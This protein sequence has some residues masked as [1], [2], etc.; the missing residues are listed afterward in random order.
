MPSILIAALWA[1]FFF[2]GCQNGTYSDI[3]VKE[4]RCEYTVEPAAVNAVNPRLYWVLESAKRGQLQAAYQVL[5]AG[6]RAGLDADKGDLWDTG[7]VNSSQSTHVVYQG[8]KLSSRM[9]C[10]W[11]VRVWDK[12]DKVSAWSKP[13]AWQMGLLDDTDWK[14]NW[15]TIGHRENQDAAPMFRREFKITGPVKEAHVYV[16]GL[17][18]Y[19]L[20]INGQKVGDHVLDPGQT[21]YQQRVFYVA[22]DVTDRLAA[23]GNAI[24][25]IVGDGW[26]NQNKVWL[27]GQYKIE[28]PGPVY[29]K[30]RLLLQLEITYADG[31]SE[32]IITDQR[33]KAATGPITANN[34]YAGENYDARLEHPGWTSAGFDDSDWDDAVLI[35]GPG[36]KLVSQSLPAIKQMKTI[37]PI[38]IVNPK[39]G[40]YVYD[41]GQNFAGWAR[42][43]I[44]GKKGERIQLRFSET[45][46]DNGMIDPASCG[47][48]ATGLVQTDTYICKGEGLEVWQPR[49]TYHGF[50]YVEMTGFSGTPTLANL[51]GIVVYTSC[52]K[53]GDFECSDAMLNRIHKTALW[54]A[55]SNIHSI[56]TDCP[57]REKCGWLGDII[58]EMLIYNL[59]V[60]LLL[61]KFVEDIET[62]RRGGIPYNIAPG[63]RLCGQDPDWGSTFIQ[64]PWY[65]YLYYG[66]TRVAYRH[67]EGMTVFMNHLQTTAKSYIIHTGIG[68]LFEPGSVFSKRTP[69][70]LTSTAFFYFDAKLMS[71]LAAVLEKTDDAES[72]GRL[73]EDIKSAFNKNFYNADN[74]TY[75]SQTTDTLALY[76][77]LVPAADRNAVADSLVRDVVEKHETHH[78]TG[79][80]GSRYI[81]GQLARYGYGHAVQQMLNQTTYPSIGELFKRG[82]TTFWEYWGEKHIDETSRGTRSQNHPFQGGYD[83]WF[84]DGIAG[85]SPDPDNPGFKNII[86]RP[87][88]I[89]NLT[90]ARA[91]YQSIH[92][93]IE[94]HWQIKSDNFHWSVSIPC[95]TTATVYIP[96]EDLQ[97]VTES[98]QKATQAQTVKFLR[99]EAG[100]A[101]FAVGSGSYR[102]VSKIQR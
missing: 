77:E 65:L 50:R 80:M 62:G 31:S 63:R 81:Y 85:I 29:G 30:T 75:G 57:A 21:D 32:T 11:K 5:V 82:A 84:F 66:D 8:R 54:T 74:K 33:W 36:G 95:N 89:G 76:L 20:S 40:V 38:G 71:E 60:P 64:L 23:G 4:L 26:Y 98:G 43:K 2:G 56:V 52:Q 99:I 51:E 34:L 72:Y 97:S 22:Y 27:E 53:T 6:S 3:N 47:G 48:Y 92:G 10:C 78:S 7:K 58:A 42:L 13:A 70:K 12:D 18:Y 16:C 93:T 79:H 37:Q 19:E 14:A 15:I 61:T 49:F 69:V 17:G 59:D 25:V 44:A 83:S 67:Y 96:T 9:K 68:D 39:P 94:S 55:T 41:M 100:K 73:A 46:F 91:R 28:P 24:G 101:V 90:F 87:Q 45:V 102:F 35:D 86:F 88:P 1:A